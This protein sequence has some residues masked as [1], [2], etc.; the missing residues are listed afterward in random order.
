MKKKKLFKKVG[1]E[2][3]I[4]ILNWQDTPEEE[5]TLYA[6]AY[7]QVAKEAV[8]E[9]QKYQ[10]PGNCK[11]PIDDFRAYPIV[12]LYRH[13]LELYMKAV[14]LVGTPMLEIKNIAKINRDKLLNT[15]SLDSLRQQIEKVFSAFEWDWDLGTPNFK[16]LQDFRTVIS[17]L[18]EIDIGSYVF[19]YPLTTEGDP[20]LPLRFEFNLLEFCMTLDSLFP[21]LEGAAYFAYEQLQLE[22]ELR[23][24]FFNDI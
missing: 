8:A 13:S 10:H 7:H 1:T 12:F 3:E 15:H 21:A 5:F 2:N 17:E 6:E 23:S 14:I 4:V 22:Y 18:H 19:R 20:S 16:T 11:L 24:E 9:F